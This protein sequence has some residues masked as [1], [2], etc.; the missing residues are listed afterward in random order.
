M[1]LLFADDLKLLFS[2]PDF[3]D[4]LWRLY[5]WNLINGMI[6]NSDKTECLHFSGTAQ[7]S[8]PPD[9]SLEDVNSH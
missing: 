4:D 8:F 3:H 1:V 5:S 7:V 2:E 9:L 6:I